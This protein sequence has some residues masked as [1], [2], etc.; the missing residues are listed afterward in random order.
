MQSP[1]SPQPVHYFVVPC[2]AEKVAHDAPAAE[3]YTGSLFQEVLANV[4]DEARATEEL[5][6]EPVQV[7]I[8]SALHGFL[9]LEE[10]VAPY[11]V[12]MGQ[13]GSITAEQLAVQV[14]ARGMAEAQVWSFLPNAY[15]VRLEAALAAHGGFTTNVYEGVRGCGDQKRVAKTMRSGDEACAREL[16]LAA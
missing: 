11:S 10:V 3:L 9:T 8:L 7:L 12:K 4:V 16:A 15:R 2:G 6:G 13:A 14:E 5:L 1:A